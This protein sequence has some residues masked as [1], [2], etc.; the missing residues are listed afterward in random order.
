V[1][2]PIACKCGR[3][4]GS[5]G[6]LSYSLNKRIVCRCKDCQ[7]FYHYLGRLDL[8]LPDGGSEVIPIH[9]ARLKFSKGQDVLACVRMSDDGLR[10]WYTSCCKTPLA[11]THHRNRLPF[12]GFHRAALVLPADHG[13]GEIYARING[14]N[15]EGATRATVAALKFIAVGFLRG[16]HRPWPFPDVAPTVGTDAEYFALIDKVKARWA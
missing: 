2:I 16:L 9:P 7:A 3:L 5:A 15:P 12:A 10:R 8:L 14:P 4:Q 11:N 13:L 6:P 1:E